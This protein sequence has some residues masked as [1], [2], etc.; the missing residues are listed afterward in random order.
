LAAEL[1]NEGLADVRYLPNDCMCR[2]CEVLVSFGRA[3]SL[4]LDSL[5]LGCGDLVDRELVDDVSA[6]VF[7]FLLILPRVHHGKFA[8]L[9]AEAIAITFPKFVEG[10]RRIPVERRT[11]EVGATLYKLYKDYVASLTTCWC[12]MSAEQVLKLW[13]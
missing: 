5:R 2:Q 12:N 9:V 6:R 1:E 10:N 4:E 7:S 8:R 11:K 13:E 3:L